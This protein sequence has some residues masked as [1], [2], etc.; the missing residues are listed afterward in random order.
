MQYSMRSEQPL[1]IDQTR[2]KIQILWPEPHAKAIIIEFLPKFE[3]K[4]HL[5]YNSTKNVQNISP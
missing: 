4:G 3:Q 2:V 5:F 1:P